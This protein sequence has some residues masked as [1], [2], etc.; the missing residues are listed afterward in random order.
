MALLAV[1]SP[2]GRAE[3]ARPYGGKAPAAVGASPQLYVA[4]GAEPGVLYSWP[5]FPKAIQ[6]DD[7]TG[8]YGL[9]WSRSS[10]SAAR[11]TGTISEDLCTKSCAGGPV[12][13]FPV[14]LE[15]SR[16]GLCPVTTSEVRSHETY[17]Y[18]RRVYVYAELIGQLPNSSGAPSAAKSVLDLSPGC[19]SG[20]LPSTN[21]PP[22][23]WGSGSAPAGL[24]AWGRLQPVGPGRGTE[25]VS[26]AST[27]SCLVVGGNPS[28][29]GARGAVVNESSYWNGT[30]WSA[31]QRFG[32]NA[33]SV[34]SVSCA[35]ATSA[36]KVAKP[37]A[38]CVAVDDAGDA[39]VFNGLRWTAPV[40]ADRYGN[41]GS[42]SCPRR[43]ACM[44]VDYTGRALA[45]D[46]QHW[47][48]PVAIDL[49]G[50]VRSVSCPATTFCMAVGSDGRAVSYDG[51]SWSAPRLIDR[52]G[53]GLFAVSCP[54]TRFCVAV[55]FLARVLTW[56]G[57]SWSAP[58]YVGVGTAGADG[59]GAPISCASTHL[60]VLVDRAGNA[61]TYDGRAWSAPTFV[62]PRAGGLSS[63]S[64]PS[65]TS[66]V[67]VDDSG[68][69]V[70]ARSVNLRPDALGP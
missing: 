66:C 64:C 59:Y 4:T 53:G 29:P 23:D 55:D 45:Y 1:M 28:Y 15:A 9:R 58:R 21:W 42:V 32:V 3:P 30:S 51:T 69:A 61:F 18:S 2:A 19:S 39:M 25:L 13:K 57:A 50:N 33:T 67:A 68:D 46:G 24:L 35:P 36:A 54:S 12:E 7:S 34:T 20:P 63:V 44:A 37:S 16:P 48:T 11:A 31:A 38:W 17:Q 60:C 56:D 26:C 41:L 40:P 5:R 65:A 6:V 47:L 8:L 14:V 43:G 27:S 10:L 52:D 70:A 62:D 22:V 49:G